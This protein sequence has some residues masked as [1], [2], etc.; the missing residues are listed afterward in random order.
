MSSKHHDSKKSDET[1]PAQACHLCKEKVVFPEH[2]TQS[3]ICHKCQT[4]IG[5]VI[6]I[7]FVITAGIVFFG[8]I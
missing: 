7:I 5:V 4:K 1:K 8:L 3:G 6:L 2:P